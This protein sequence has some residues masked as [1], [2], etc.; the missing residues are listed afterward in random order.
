MKIS[1]RVW[2]LA[3]VRHGDCKERGEHSGRSFNGKCMEDRSGSFKDV[4][5]KELKKYGKS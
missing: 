3:S 2:G 4:L 1:E 5:S